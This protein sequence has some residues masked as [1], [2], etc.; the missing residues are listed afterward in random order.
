MMRINTAQMALSYWNQSEEML[1]L[2]NSMDA[3]A[4]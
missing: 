1:S 3:P 4:F 2:R